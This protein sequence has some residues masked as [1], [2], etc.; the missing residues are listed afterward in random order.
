MSWINGYLRIGLLVLYV[1]DVSDVFVDLLKLSNYL[2]LEGPRCFFGT[3]IAYV[4]TVTGWMYWRLYQY[5]VRVIWASFT[6]MLRVT[7]PSASSPHTLFGFSFTTP[8]MPLIIE[9]YVLLTLLL[10]L[11]VYWFHLFAMIGY[12]ILT[13]NVREASR[14]EYEGDSDDDVH[15]E[16]AEGSSIADAAKDGTSSPVGHDEGA[17]KTAEGTLRA[18]KGAASVASAAQ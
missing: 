7:A 13:E 17:G 18:R 3:E 5:P 9:L 15:A 4:A 14:Q 11:H 10:V 6:G 1:H 12:R 2:K 16:A 8:D